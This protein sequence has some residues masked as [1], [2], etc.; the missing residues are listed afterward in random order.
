MLLALC[1]AQLVRQ[2]D[3]AAAVTE[4]H[5]VYPDFSMERM[6]SEF[7]GIQ[8]QPTLAQYLDGARKAG[9]RECATSEELQKYPKMIHLAGCDAR[10]ATN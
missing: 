8:D 4:L 3:K 9:L 2:S 7:G 10:R 6:F 5:R 1:Y